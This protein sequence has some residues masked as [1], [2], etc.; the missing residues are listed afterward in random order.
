MKK[1]REKRRETSITEVI[2]NDQKF[3]FSRVTFDRAN[4]KFTI[5]YN[6]IGQTETRKICGG[7]NYVKQLWSASN[8]KEITIE[9]V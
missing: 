2:G 6:I 1:I 9:I 4:G 7:N 3:E 5:Y 8:R